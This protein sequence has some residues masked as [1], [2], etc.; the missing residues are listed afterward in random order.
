MISLPLE[1]SRM[2]WSVSTSSLVSHACWA[3]G[4][5][6][7]LRQP[8]VWNTPKQSVRYL[9][10]LVYGLIDTIRS[11]PPS[12]WRSEESNWEIVEY[13]LC[14]WSQ[15]GDLLNIQT[16]S[17]ATMY[18]WSGRSQGRCLRMRSVPNIGFSIRIFV[19]RVQLPELLSILAPD[20]LSK[21]S[22]RQHSHH[23]S[24]P[25]LAIA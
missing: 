4:W 13:I 2:P 12:V 8:L 1:I 25:W 5:Q 7:W 20:T 18:G 11:Y 6:V 19:P 24:S 16:S 15:F 14:E 10:R 21:R 17:S 23:L 3:L 22:C 9:L